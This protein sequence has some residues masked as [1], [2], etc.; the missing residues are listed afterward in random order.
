MQITDRAHGIDISKYDQWFTPGSATGQ[1]DFVIQRT[2]YGTVTDERFFQ[3]QPGVLEM[4]IRGGYH[5]LSS[6]VPWQD[7]AD[8]MLELVGDTHHFLAVDYEK[9]YNNL[10]RAFADACYQTLQYLKKYFWGKVLLYTNPDVYE[11]FLKIYGDWPDNEELWLGQY[12][13]FPSPNKNP[14]LPA[15]R[16]EWT[17]WQYTDKGNGP[18]YGVA[19]PTACD[20]DVFNGTVDDLRAWVGIQPT[21][22]PPPEPLTLEERV[23]ELEVAVFGKG[24]GYA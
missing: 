24:G 19:R 13:W 8:L 12:W 23:T 20:L 18:L 9:Y 7:Q 17:F 22:P 11:N 3:L 2:G 4:Q 1:L 6:A 16:S 10:N 5:Y 15:G 21:L 14:G